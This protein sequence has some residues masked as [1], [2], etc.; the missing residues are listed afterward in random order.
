MSVPK[1]DMSFAVRL[2]LAAWIGGFLLFRLVPELDL[3]TAGLFYRAGEG[4]TVITNPLWEWL[5]QRIWDIS[6]VLFVVSLVAWPW[7]GLRHRTVLRLPARIWAFIC[8]LYLLGPIVVVNGVLKANSGRARPANVDLFGGA[9]HFSLPGTFTD[10]CSRN[11][12]F[13]SGEVAA[14]VALGLLI[15]LG[16]ELRRAH[17]PRWG[18]LY[19]RAVGVFVAVFII[20][21]R[22][23]TGRHFLS[24][25]YFAGLVSLTVAWLLW[26]I[27]FA[28]WG[29]RLVAQ[30]RG[31]AR[32]ES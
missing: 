32:R 8:L 10:Q 11:C 2:L 19:L 24:D 26:G 29:A 18:V 7:A 12:S 9:H 5:R 14:A 16:A 20:V 31:E 15:W 22:I 6:I 28:G 27:L 1:I 25:T 21:Q 4:F 23:G 17:L 3:G 13:V 30:V